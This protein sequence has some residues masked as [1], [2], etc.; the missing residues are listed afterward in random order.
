MINVTHYQAETLTGA[1]IQ[2]ADLEEVQSTEHNLSHTGQHPHLHIQPSGYLQLF[3]EWFLEVHG[4]A[5]I[6]VCLFGIFTNI[7]NITVLMAKDMRTATNHLLTFLA[8]ADI[9]TMVPYI[10]YAINFY[11]PATSPVESPWKY[12][13][14]WILYILIMVHFLATT[15]I[16][17]IWLAVT[18]AAFRFTQIRSPCPRGPLAKER[19]IRQVKIATAI[20]YLTSILVMIPNYVSNEIERNLVP[21]INASTFGIKEMKIGTP[22]AELVVFTNMLTYAVLG[23][24]LPCVLILIFS[25]S[26]LYNMGIKTTRRRQRLASS[27]QHIKTTRMLLAVLVMFLFTE[28]PQGTFII[29]SATVPGFYDEINYPLGDLMDFVALLNNA[30]NFVLYCVMSQQF[31]E[32]FFNIYIKPLCERRRSLITSTSELLILREHVPR[33]VTTT[34]HEENIKV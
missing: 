18:L 13:Y 25:G 33:T 32:K 15:H 24:L 31:R 9:L 16:I 28:L 10:P 21:N 1:V 5:S 14:G 29:L 22:Q 19:R 11:C 4:Y 8:V 3:H 20:V 2:R 34:T 23:K 27:S 6:V 7:F 12:S 26:L 30:I 17:S